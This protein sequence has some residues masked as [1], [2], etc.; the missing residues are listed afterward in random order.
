MKQEKSFSDLYL[1]ICKVIEQARMQCCTN[2][3]QFTHTNVLEN[4]RANQW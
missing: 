2:G 1:D 3:E 4:W